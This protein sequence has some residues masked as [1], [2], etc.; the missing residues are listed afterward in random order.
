M[1]KNIEVRKMVKKIKPLA[2]KSVAAT[3]AIKCYEEQLVLG[4]DGIVK[5]IK[6][7]NKDEFQV[8]AINHN[9]TDEKEHWHILVRA[10]SREKKFQVASMM[11]RLIP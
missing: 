8:I 11:K 1:G 4:A 6:N 3:M 7:I 9:K 10:V 5:S 2:K